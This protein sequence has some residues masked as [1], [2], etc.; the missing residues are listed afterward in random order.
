MMSRLGVLG[1]MFDPVHIGHIA[2]ANHAVS[3]LSLNKV[4]MI[5]CNQPNHRDQAK[6]SSMHRLAMLNIA[7]D[8]EDKIEVDDCEISRGGVSYTADTLKRLRDSGIAEHIVFIFGM[9]SLNSID[10]WHE[11]ESLFNSA[12]FL[13]L[14]RNDERVDS[15]VAKAINFE[16]RRVLNSQKLFEAPA[17]RIFISTD[18][19]NPSSSTQ[20]RKELAGAKSDSTQLLPAV[21]DYI[22]ENRLYL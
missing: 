18:F 19:S 5:P 17:G 15:E 20:V 1:G 21:N 14:A 12:H 9:D 11:W 6:A 2:A 3:L 8:A 4:K 22:I 13:V 7:T 10:H 16:D